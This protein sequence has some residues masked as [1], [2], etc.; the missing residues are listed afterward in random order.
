MLANVQHHNSYGNIKPTIESYKQPSINFPDSRA[1]SGN[2]GKFAPREN[3][4]LYG[5]S[6]QNLALVFSVPKSFLCFLTFYIDPY[7]VLGLFAFYGTASKVQ[8]HC[9]Y[10]AVP[11]HSSRLFQLKPIGRLF[12]G[13]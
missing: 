2:S 3:N 4:P 8:H 5:I 10:V 9:T 6:C 1:H 13:V 12:Y 11:T 7:Y